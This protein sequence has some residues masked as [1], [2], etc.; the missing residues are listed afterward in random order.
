M[1]QPLKKKNSKAGIFLVA[2][3]IFIALA[4]VVTLVFGDSIHR[5][6]FQEDRTVQ[7]RLD[8]P[9][10]FRDWLSGALQGES[11][12]LS[13]SEKCLQTLECANYLYIPSV[14]LSI[15]WVS[16]SVSSADATGFSP[17]NL[18]ESGIG[19]WVNTTAP[20]GS[21]TGTTLFASHVNYPGW[22]ALAPMYLIYN[23][24]VGDEVIIT[25]ENAHHHVFRVS[26][27]HRTVPQTQL[28]S[29]Y[30]LMYSPEEDTAKNNVLLVT[31]E[32]TVNADGSIAY[33]LNHVVELEPVDTFV[34][35]ESNES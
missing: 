19:A 23:A 9:D 14:G 25:D 3:G 1:S 31:C 16:A 18:P 7:E 6:L 27:P 21:P 13:E 2:T 33:D 12:E 8:S 15:P 24:Q 17:V 30:D 11:D 35:G 29:V 34:E 22:N 32:A 20:L 4:G 5:W 10:E 28:A 26:K